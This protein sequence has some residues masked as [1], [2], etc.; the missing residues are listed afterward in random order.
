MVWAVLKGGTG[1]QKT[2]EEFQS[3]TTPL[4]LAVVVVVVG[5]W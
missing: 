5:G 4:N 2:K 3:S 1:L